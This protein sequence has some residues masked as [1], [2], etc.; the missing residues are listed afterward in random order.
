MST[1]VANSLAP[2]AAVTVT[3]SGLSDVD[4]ALVWTLVAGEDGTYYLT[5]GGQ[6]LS[7]SKGNVSLVDA[8]VPFIVTASSVVASTTTDRCLMLQ[9]YQGTP[10]FKNYSQKNIGSANYSSAITVYKYVEG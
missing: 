1:E 3:D 9:D 4:A 10:R 6:Q 5:A 8:G 2:A 7:V